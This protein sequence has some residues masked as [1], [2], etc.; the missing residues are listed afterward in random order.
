ML[1][2]ISRKDSMSEVTLAHDVIHNPSEPRHFMKIKPVEKTVSIWLDEILIAES[3]NAV[4][5]LE[6]GYDLYDPVFYIPHQDLKY[7]LK[8]IVG[9]RTHCPI[10]GSAVYYDLEDRLTPETYLA[11]CYEETYE[12]ANSLKG[13]IAFNSQLV[14]IIEK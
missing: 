14:S 6:V 11:W 8:T 1:D 7:E 2:P 4:R 12:F 3:V 10:K 13:M 5:L 9:K